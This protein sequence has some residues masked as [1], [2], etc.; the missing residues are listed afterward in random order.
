MAAVTATTYKSP[1]PVP[2]DLGEGG[3][4]LSS[5]SSGEP[6]LGQLLNDLSSPI[7]PVTGTAD[8][9]WS[10]NEVDMVNEMVRIV[11]NFL[12]GATTA[13]T[14]TVTTTYSASTQTILGKIKTDV[15]A[16]GAGVASSAGATYDAGT[17][18]NLGDLKTAVNSLC[19]DKI[20]VITPGTYTAGTAKLI[21][22]LC[23]RLNAKQS[24]V[25]R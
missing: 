7:P 14:D 6:R 1:N 10:Q 19:S 12:P 17:V 16:H 21:S 9:T 5:G 20:T 13:T 2:K 23:I 25:N 18:T 4:H 11:S 15:N 24:M 22:Q 3:G 8:A